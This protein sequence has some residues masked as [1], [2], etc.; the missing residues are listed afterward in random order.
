MQ[1]CGGD[2]Q[3]ANSQKATN[4]P[5]PRAE[6]SNKTK[7]NVEELG[8]LVNIPYEAEDSVWQEDAAQKEITA[9]LRFTPPDCEKIVADAVK[10]GAAEKVTIQSE[11]WFPDELIAQGRLSGDDTLKGTSYPANAFFQD[12]FVDGRLIRIDETSYFVLEVSSK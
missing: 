3:N 7:T 6:K 2:K 12:D 1:A 10:Y 8:M 9:V 5:S 11:S 4:S